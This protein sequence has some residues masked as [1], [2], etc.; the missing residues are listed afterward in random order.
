MAVTDTREGAMHTRNP[1]RWW[2]LTALAVTL[3]VF[4]MDLTIVNVALPTLALELEANTAQLQWFATSYM[5]A[6]ASLLIPAGTLSDRFGHK[7][8]LLVSLGV[9]AA[10]SLACAYAT[11]PETLIAARVL[12]GIGGA[13]LIP[14]SMSITYLLFDPAERPRA[15]GVWAAAIAVGVPVGPVIA[16][17]LLNHFWWGSI[18]LI[19]VP[20]I[21]IGVALLA[22]LLPAF[23]PRPGMAIDVVGIVISA[24]ALTAFTYGVMSA[25]NDGW[26]DPAALAYLAGGLVGFAA[27]V[28]WLRR[29]PAPLFSLSL[30]A[31]PGFLWGT[32]FATLAS[33]AL[34]GLIFVAPQLI[35]ANFGVDALGTGLRLLPMVGGLVAGS[36]LS[37][38]LRARVR[39]NL[40]AAVGF[41]ALGAG[42]AAGT[43]NEVGSSYSVHAAWMAV[44]GAGVGL[45]LPLTMDVAMGSLTES[46]AGVGSGV[47]QALRQV[48]G[49]LGVAVL[50]TVLS[51]TYT[52]RLDLA[53]LPGD[54][55]AHVE[56]SAA[57]GVQVA[58][59]LNSAELLAHVRESFLAGAHTVLWWCAAVMAL[60]SL[61]ALRFLPARAADQEEL[62]HDLRSTP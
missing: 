28:G 6:L 16:G 47:L 5:L 46:G 15:M 2:I 29:A 60:S 41:L 32:I 4:S 30:L 56:S 14:A 39:A 11:S 20:I 55:A 49:A 27:L 1:H 9:F 61:L 45:T 23:A 12:L 21:V 53:P 51:S 13:F 58:E 34:M 50:G 40:I 36:L 33:F 3:I 22:V 44:V 52:D 26:G 17:L 59:R 37:D 62:A 24:A 43:L 18:F 7:R 42:A 48:G 54:L 57:A 35:Q 10:G 8:V 19:N 31:S 38:A 25:G